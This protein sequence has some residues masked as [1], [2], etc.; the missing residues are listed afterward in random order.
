M[1]KS[2][3][4]IEFLPIFKIELFGEVLDLLVD[5]FQELLLSLFRCL[6]TLALGQE[7]GC[8]HAEERRQH[9]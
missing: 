2:G 9:P 7:G 6:G 3:I 1:G 4:D 5:G 8:A